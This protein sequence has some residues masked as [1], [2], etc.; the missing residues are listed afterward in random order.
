MATFDRGQTGQWNNEKPVHGDEQRR[1]LVKCINDYIM[2]FH[3][4]AVNEHQFLF[5]RWN[6][7]EK[8][9]KK[10]EKDKIAGIEKLMYG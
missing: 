9:G 10:M 8:D 1:N 3:S 6:K 7:K 5:D 2:L 4:K